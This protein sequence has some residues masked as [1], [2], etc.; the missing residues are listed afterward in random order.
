MRHGVWTIA[1]LVAALSRPA[2]GAA[3]TLPPGGYY[4][5]GAYY[6]SSDPS[7]TPSG[8]V[9]A[10]PPCPPGYG[11][12]T[13]YVARTATAVLIRWAAPTWDA[14]PGFPYVPVYGS[15]GRC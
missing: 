3:Q 11:V 2:H 13:L 14:A 10:S 9:S 6:V 15:E 12:P 1:V 7:I 8:P 5:D 4:A